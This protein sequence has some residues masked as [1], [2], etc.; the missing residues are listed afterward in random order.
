MALVCGMI[1]D[2]EAHY[3]YWVQRAAGIWA[4]CSGWTDHGPQS[5]RE[6]LHFLVIKE[7]RIYSGTF[8]H[9]AEKLCEINLVSYLNYDKRN[10]YLVCWQSVGSFF[11]FIKLDHYIINVSFSAICNTES[12]KVSLSTN[13][14]W[15]TKL[16]NNTVSILITS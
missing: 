14:H 13:C 3:L 6:W 15:I 8:M 16:K 5:Q 1:A 10:I 9:M 12:N 11:F 7:Q 2:L 4:V